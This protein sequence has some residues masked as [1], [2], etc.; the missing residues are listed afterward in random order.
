MKLTLHSLI[1]A[2]VTMA[3]AALTVNPAVAQTKVNVP[4]NFV[5]AGKNCPAGTYS[6]QAGNLGNS[7]KLSGPTGSFTWIV[8]PTDPLTQDKQA[9]LQF[10]RMGQ[11]YLLRSVQL[12]AQVTSR[13]DKKYKLPPSAPLI[14]RN[15]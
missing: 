8:R 9:S 4:F 1:L 3:A 13:L 15:E 2:S 14:A 7:I 10:D 5:A 6:V 12:H 11:T